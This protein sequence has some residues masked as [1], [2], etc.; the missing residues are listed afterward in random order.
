MGSEMCIRDSAKVVDIAIN[1]AGWVLN[2][3]A[4]IVDAAYS[5]IEGMRGLVKNVFGEKGLEVFDSFLN[6]M[7]NV[8]NLIGSVGMVFAALGGV[9]MVTKL[10]AFLKGGSALATVT[11][12]T[13][14]ATTATTGGAAATAG[15]IG[16]AA[17][18]GIVA[19]AGL[20]ASGL[21]EGASVSYT[22]L[23]LPTNREV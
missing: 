20:L 4:T 23:T 8:I 2:F 19:G 3:V 21:G 5:L 17:T 13:G 14:G 12:L 15:G 11:G 16:T 1:I 6:T 18:V 7:K 10:M 22:H 9:G